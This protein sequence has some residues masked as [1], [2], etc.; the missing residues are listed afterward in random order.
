VRKTYDV[1][2]IVN[3]ASVR[4]HLAGAER[5][6]R[7][8]FLDIGPAVVAAAT[9]DELVAPVH[10]DWAGESQEW[11]KGEDGEYLGELHVEWEIGMLLKVVVRKKVFGE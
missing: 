10:F 6:R 11:H 4:L 9:A 3:V 1:R 8:D 2:L 5:A 7:S